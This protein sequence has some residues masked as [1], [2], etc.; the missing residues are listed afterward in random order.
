MLSSL[1]LRGYG[2]KG[3]TQQE[4]GNSMEVRMVAEQSAIDTKDKGDRHVQQPSLDPNLCPV[5]HLLCL[6][7]SIFGT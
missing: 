7:Q 1:G 4:I 6:Y 3:S 2:Q 5:F